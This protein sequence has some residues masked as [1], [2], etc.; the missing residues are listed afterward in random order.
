MQIKSIGQKVEY[1]LFNTAVISR[2]IDFGNFTNQ[3]ANDQAGSNSI[4]CIE[5]TEQSVGQI[6][7]SSNYDNTAD[8]GT[9]V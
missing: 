3:H 2:S 4:E 5:G 8:I 6:C 9:A 1:N 7:C